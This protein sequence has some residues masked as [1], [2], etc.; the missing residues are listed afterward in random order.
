[1]VFS[2]TS[3]VE[4]PATGCLISKIR[5]SS[6]PWDLASLWAKDAKWSEQME[7]VGI[8][9]FSRQ[10]AS[11]ITQL[12]QEP[13][14]PKAR[15]AISPEEALSICSGVAGAPAGFLTFMNVLFP[16]DSAKISNIAPA[17]GL[18]LSNMVTFSKSSGR[19]LTFNLSA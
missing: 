5:N 11:S 4:S 1:M 10:M 18:V 8:P 14:S 2:F 16:R 19:G 3:S 7:M 13:Q 17:P 6:I 12:V 15:M 9:L